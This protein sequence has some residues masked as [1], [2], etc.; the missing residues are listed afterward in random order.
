MSTRCSA[1]ILRTRG[2]DFV[3]RRCSAVWTP[4]SPSLFIVGAGAGADGGGGAALDGSGLGGAAA[5][6]GSGFAGAGAAAGF[7]ATAPA[8][9]SSTATSVC[10]GTVCPSCTLISARTPA[11]GAGISASTLSVEI[12]NNGSS[13]F[14]G[15]PTFLSHLLKVPSAIDSPICGINTSTRAMFSPKRFLVP[16]VWC[17]KCHRHQ[18]PDTRHLV[19]R[20]PSR[21]FHYIV[22]LGQDEV[23][24]SRCI[25]QRH[26][27]RGHP[28]DR[29]VEPLKRLLVD[30]RG[31][32][33]RDATGPRVLVHDQHLVRLLHGRDDRPII[34]RQQRPQIEHFHRQ[35]IFVGELVGGFQRFPQRGT[36]GNYGKMLPL[37]RQARLA[38]RRENFFA[39][40]QLFLDPPIQPFVLEIQ[41]GIVIADRGLDQ[42]LRVPD[43]RGIDDFEPGRVQERRLGILR[44]EWPAP[45]VPAAGTTHDDGR[46]QSGPVARRGDVIRQHVVGTGDEVDELHLRNGPEAHVRRAG[47][48]ADDRRLGDRRVDHARFAE[49]LGESLSDLECAAIQSDVFAE[50]EDAIVYP[51][52]VR[53]AKG[54][55]KASIRDDDPVLYLE[56]KWLY[57]RIKEQLPAGEEILTPIGQARLAREGKHLSIIT[58]GATLWK[59]L[60]AADKLANE[61]GLSVEVLDLRTLLPLDD[62]AIVAT[63]KKTN[64]VLIVHEDTRTGG[65]AGEIAARI[66]E[67]AFEWLD[68]P[69]M[70]VTAHDVPLPYAPTLEDFVLPQTDDIVKA[71]RW[72]AR[73]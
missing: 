24:K 73:Y 59:S 55:I 42:A 60:E 27:V 72:L 39:R 64:K 66:N 51:A 47:R 28:H 46:R 52:T 68:G 41:H 3:R 67:Q 34:Q 7:D 12:S 44:V 58:Y 23:L 1:A 2:V 61:D 36:V 43:R 16:G 25:R 19:F 21:R 56:H 54:L 38:D 45:H 26:I 15:S 14:T 18:E 8:S 57:R 63:V 17:Q 62:G 37:A 71:A 30:A 11:A 35:A 32:L 49:T 50:D 9:V 48:G 20:Q 33:A 29:P 13:R 53:D 40:G 10:T 69:I 6:G 22:G 5:F 65:I 70:R 4:P 31:D